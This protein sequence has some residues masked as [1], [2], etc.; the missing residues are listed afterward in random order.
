MKSEQEDVHDVRL[1]TGLEQPQ[2]QSGMM[3][4]PFPTDGTDGANPVQTALVSAAI[5]LGRG[6][7]LPNAA[8]FK[9]GAAVTQPQAVCQVQVLRRRCVATLAIENGAVERVRH[10]RAFLP[11]WAGRVGFADAAGGVPAL[12]IRV[13]A[14]VALAGGDLR[15]VPATRGTDREY[16]IGLSRQAKA[17]QEGA[18]MDEGDPLG[19]EN[20][21][22]GLMVP[23]PRFPVLGGQPPVA[24]INALDD[25]PDGLRDV[26]GV[27]RDFARSLSVQFNLHSGTPFAS[28]IHRGGGYGMA[29]SIPVARTLFFQTAHP[30]FPFEKKEA[31]ACREAPFP[32]IKGARGKP[33][34]RDRL[35]PP[36][37]AFWR[38]LR[39]QPHASGERRAAHW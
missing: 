5:A 23:G 33:G 37:A 39:V 30:L 21:D 3:P 9:G 18:S 16:G 38:G 25:T 7:T 13:R 35:W 29:W 14:L 32:S 11:G 24:G 8:A 34:N 27:H 1:A 31:K 4:G 12:R 28:A 26:W 6:G 22:Q 2:S 15:A 10:G 20:V 19:G 17:L 36:W